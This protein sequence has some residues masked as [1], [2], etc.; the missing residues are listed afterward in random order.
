VFELHIYEAYDRRMR[1]MRRAGVTF[2]FAVLLA[3][4]SVAGALTL[5]PPGKAGASQYFETI[6]T[7]SGN[8]APPQGGGSGHA[9]SVAIG[10][11]VAGSHALAKLGSDGQA[12]AALAVATAPVVAASSGKQGASAGSQPSGSKPP[13]SSTAAGGSATSQPGGSAVGGVANALTGSDQGGI[14][15]FLPLLML[16]TLAVAVW[17]GVRNARRSGGPPEQSA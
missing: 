3:V 6:P 9:A 11:G 5:A 8:A 16:L 2:V 1:W 17:A 15:L 13:T 10:N 14:G 7:S 4:P 12:A